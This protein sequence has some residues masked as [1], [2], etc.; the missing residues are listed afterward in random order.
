VKGAEPPEGVMVA[1]PFVPPLHE[2]FV[3]LDERVYVLPLTERVAAILV[4]H[5]L[6]AATEIFPEELPD[7]TLIE[8]VVDVPVQPEGKFHV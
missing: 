4:P 5:A 7:V 8:L 6:L 2:M 3:M 1:E